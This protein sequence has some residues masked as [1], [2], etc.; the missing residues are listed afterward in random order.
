LRSGSHRPAASGGSDPAARPGGPVLLAATSNADKARE[1]ELLLDPVRRSLPFR[2]RTLR[3][4]EAR[5]LVEDKETFAGNAVLKALHA[6]ER[7]GVVSLGEDSGLEVEALDGAPGVRSARFSG[8]GYEDN[9]RLLLRLLEGVPSERRRARFTTA[10]ALKVPGGPLYL[11]QGHAEGEILTE[12]RGRG[13]FGYDP[14]FFSY[15]LGRAFA[16]VSRDEKGR[17]SHRSRALRALRGYLFEAFPH[18][19]FAASESA[20]PGHARC[21]GDLRLAGAPEQGVIHALAVAR[22]AAEAALLL[23]EEGLGVSP[24]A[25]RAAG[26]LHDIGKSPAA[27][28]EAGT[29]RG[30]APPG[31]TEHAWH[32]AA[33]AEARGYD[34][35]VVRAVMVHG[36]D[37][38][39]SDEYQPG[40]WEERV[41]ALADKLAED[42]YVPLEA[43]LRGL[44]ERHPGIGHLVREAGPRLQALEAE[45]ARAC[46]LEVG[47]LGRRLE[48]VARVQVFPA[49]S[50]PES[51]R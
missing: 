13:G 10:A 39:L 15:D 46:G 32:S 35:R 36:L 47:E 38:M 5:G 16:E 11:A 1:I 42:T 41:V 44:L 34:A 43:R 12:P 26:L 22:L 30:A 25:A 14:V 3:A 29:G 45:T 33:W 9:N 6:A 24:A 8:G 18:G 37:S 19:P 2:L 17:V 31:V 40:T 49:E 7:T 51:F 4:G 20:V 28:T 50:R 48:A 23:V 27:V 21:L